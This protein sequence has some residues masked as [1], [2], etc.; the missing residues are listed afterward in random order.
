M[1]TLMN[2]PASFPENASPA[3]RW[4]LNIRSST[5]NQVV[6]ESAL[7]LPIPQQ[8]GDHQVLAAF[9]YGVKT[10]GGPGKGIALPPVARLAAT[11]P[12]GRIIEFIRAEPEMLFPGLEISPD[13]GP[14]ATGSLS[15]PERTQTRRA[16]FRLYPE[17]L[18]GYRS[19]Q[20]IHQRDAF[21]KLFYALISPG[22][23]PFY[24]HLNPQFFAWM[25]A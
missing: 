17:I 18:D 21:K 10:T 22:L 5:F 15:V 1:S 11:Y 19:M 23:V 3:H 25:K 20:M 6:L 7:S 2:M 13:L 14:L 9:Y 24:E 16:F 4:W 8:P 12:E